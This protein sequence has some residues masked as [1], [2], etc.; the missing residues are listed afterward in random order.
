MEHKMRKIAAV[1]AAVTVVTTASAF[2]MSPAGQELINSIFSYFQNDQAIEITSLKELDK[3]NEE[4]GKSV[5]KDGVTLTLDNVAADDNFI[6]IF[7]TVKSDQE[8]LYEGDRPNVAVYNDKMNM[9]LDICGVINGI[10]PQYNNH[11]T[12]DG[13][14]VDNHTY[15]AVEKYNI[16]SEEI[17]DRFRVELF[18]NAVHKD[19]KFREKEVMK[20][21]Y[22]DGGYETI[23]EAERAEVL[24]ISAE[25]D[26]SKT[27][28]ETVTKE[29]NTKLPWCN[30]TVEKIVF[31]P[32]GNQMVI[33]T[34]PA[35]DQDRNPAFVDSCFALYDE[36]GT[37]LDMLNTDLCGSSDGSLRNS[38]EFLKASAD[39]KQLKFVPIKFNE[40]GD[41]GRTEYPI[42]QYPITCKFSDYGSIVV[43]DIRIS[44]GKVEID[45]YKDGYVLYDPAFQLL[46]DNGGNAEPGGKLGCVLYTDVHHDTNSYT[47]R[48][49]YDK[50]D[51]N[52]EPVPPDESVSADALKKSF[53]TLGFVD[54]S[55]IELD[56]DR[57]ITVGLR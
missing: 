21:L 38:F 4:I 30:G 48:Y 14:F 27:Q 55:Y 29:I 37:C 11:S 3:Y 7:Y 46:D 25:I 32:F 51:N 35:V 33:S 15:K 56:F 16:S 40:R 9:Y 36:N 52:G 53:T 54:Q 2:A 39:T 18:C 17:P 50:L 44:D 24:Y 31:S 49:V 13:Y 23:T 43:T 34:P 28:V 10:F 42:G 22:Q 1:A 5:S 20:K 19:E 6:H 41:I 47:A 45:Y 8:P 57:A 26:K 12:Q